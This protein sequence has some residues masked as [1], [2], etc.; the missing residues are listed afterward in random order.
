[1]KKRRIFRKKEQDTSAQAKA[2]VKKPVVVP[3]D[4]VPG[5]KEGYFVDRFYSYG[6]PVDFVNEKMGIRTPIIRDHAF[7]NFSRGG[8]GLLDG[9]CGEIAYPSAF[10]LSCGVFQ[11]GR[12]GAHANPVDASAA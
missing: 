1:M 11:A 12:A 3:D 8:G 6:E 4:S 10:W 9:G 5:V 7:L 2:K